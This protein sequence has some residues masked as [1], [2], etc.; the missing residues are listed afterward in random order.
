M[1]QISLK[2]IHTQ[3]LLSMNVRVLTRKCEY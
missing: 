2:I 3:H 1:I